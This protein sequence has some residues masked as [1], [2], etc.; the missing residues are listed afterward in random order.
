[1]CKKV[2][3]GQKHYRFADYAFVRVSFFSNPQFLEVFWTK[4]M[5]VW[6]ELMPDFKFVEKPLTMLEAQLVNVD[7]IADSLDI[8]LEEILS[9]KVYFF[10]NALLDNCN[11][12][13]FLSRYFIFLKIQLDGKNFE[14]SILPKIYE[15]LS[16]SD[17]KDVVSPQSIELGLW[18]KVCAS[19]N[20]LWTILDPLAFK[21]IDDNISA[22]GTYFVEYN[23]EDN[24][25]ETRRY[26]R[27]LQEDERYLATIQVKT[28]L[29]GWNLESQESVWNI[30][31]QESTRCFAK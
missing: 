17:L 13:I 31:K 18:H 1:M 22:N 15:L 24:F 20:D 3:Y 11:I 16:L 4:K 25:I 6:T 12:D 27:Q 26:L 30:L 19:R 5:S 2:E 14:E 10:S 7:E 8:T 29:G 9:Q 23:V 28:D 21:S